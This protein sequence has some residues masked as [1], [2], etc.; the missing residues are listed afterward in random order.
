[1]VGI[2][3]Q[4]RHAQHKALGEVPNLF[5][6]HEEADTRLILHAHEA[7]ANNFNRIVVLCRDTDVL[8][9]LIHFFGK[10]EEIETWMVGGNA[11]QKKC[12]PVNSI[13]DKL[14]EGVI[15]NILGFHAF[16]GCDTT[17]SFSGY[18]KKKCW[19]VFE[20]HPHLLYGIG[21]DCFVQDVE[22]F[23]FRLYC[24]PD[25]LAGVNQCRVDLFERG[26]KELEKLPPTKNSLGLHITRCNFQANVWLQATVKFL[27]LPLPVVTGG[28]KASDSLDNLEIVWTT[29]PSIPTCCLSLISCGCRTKCK[30]GA[31]KCYKSQQQCTPICICNAKDCNNPIGL[32]ES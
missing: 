25:P 31:C 30:S 21:R 6:N 10:N 14:S 15:Q 17:S 5:S 22:E 1:M 7:I 8:L 11:K 19:K 27:E 2:W 13:T 16:T 23:V 20:E 32:A 12:F 9:L 26:S 28:W 18:G 4:L 3:I 24:A 29:L